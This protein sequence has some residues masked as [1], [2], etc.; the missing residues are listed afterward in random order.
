MRIGVVGAGGVG[1][2]LAG[3]AARAGLDVA[4]LARGE[5]LA[6]VRADGLQVT[7]GEERF[8]VRPAA[9]AGDAA[10]LG[11]CDAVLVAVKS[12]QVA[13]LAPS[14]APL[15]AP[16]GVVIPL[17]N[18]VEAAE[19]LAAG[20]PGV[21]V[22][23]G[24]TY[25][26]A[27]SDGPGRIRL[28]GA[29]LR[30]VI[31]ERPGAP[32]GGALAPLAAALGGAGV[33][34][35]VSDRIDAVAWEKLLFVGPFGAAGAVSRAPAGAMRETPETRRLLAG[36]IGEGAAVARARGVALPDD[37][38]ERTLALLDRVA[39]EATVSMQRDLAAGRPS[40][41]LDQT[42]VVARLGAEAGVPV[43]LHDALL[44][45]LLPLERSARSE[46]RRFQRT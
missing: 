11:Q 14:L 15:I 20:L 10:G 3:L 39:W 23:G 33:M 31:G 7:T 16:G 45:A 37:V 2:L 1:G 12:W 13:A 22:A 28:A 46:A 21:G 32:L 25:V 6:A 35:E 29:P 4:L 5:T 40:E 36:L 9:V 41:L 24:V 43:P 42:G 17:Q 34:T 27:W 38:L 30:L 19:R 44:A 8:T 18:G 26:F